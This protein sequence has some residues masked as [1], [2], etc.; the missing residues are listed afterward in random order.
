MMLPLTVF[1]AYNVCHFIALWS[2]V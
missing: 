1:G 2:L